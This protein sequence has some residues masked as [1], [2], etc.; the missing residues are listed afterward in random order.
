MPG[1]SIL[2]SRRDFVSAAKVG[3]KFVSASLV[4]QVRKRPDQAGPRV[5][6]T[7][8]RKIGGAVQRN[9]AKRRLRAL[10]RDCLLPRA[11]PSCDY[12]LIARHNTGQIPWQRLEA[13]CLHLLSRHGRKSI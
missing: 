8:T 3:D 7:A 12:V 10:A 13:D 9:R 2:K 11:D 4:L 6:F 1:V 5:G